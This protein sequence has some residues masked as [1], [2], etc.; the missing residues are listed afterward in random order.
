M[1]RTVIQLPERTHRALKHLAVD[2]GAS[3]AAVIRE[4]VERTYHEDIADIERAQKLLAG[5]RPGTG[6]PLHQY[7]RERRKSRRV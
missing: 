1:M 2:R 7:H 4:A 3:L 6:V 5:Y